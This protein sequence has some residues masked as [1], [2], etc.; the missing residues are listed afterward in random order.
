MIYLLDTNAISELTRADARIENWISALDRGDRVITCTIV[1]GE[2]LVGIARLPEGKRRA[3][4]EESGQQFLNAQSRLFCL[5][6]SASPPDSRCSCE[7]EA[8]R[9][10]C[11]TG[12]RVRPQEDEGRVHSISKGTG[13]LPR[14]GS[15][16]RR[17]TGL[18]FPA[19][20]CR[21]G[22]CRFCSRH[23]TR[24]I[25]ILGSHS[26]PSTRPWMSRRP[27]WHSWRGRR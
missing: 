23:G 3:E 19:V 25:T 4:L 1:R 14:S 26:R 17:R 8:C 16:H 18:P 15:G 6:C 22:L 7:R 24:P 20:N 11:P 9:P 12:T 13:K 21:P 2:M 10:A 5:L 27:A